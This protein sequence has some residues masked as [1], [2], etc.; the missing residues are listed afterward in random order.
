MALVLH[1]SG[2]QPLGQ[3]DGVDAITSTV[4]GGEVLTFTTVSIASDKASADVA[5]GYLAPG[6]SRIAL[7]TTLTSGSRPLMLCDDGTTYYGTLFGSLVG[8]ACGQVVNGPNTFNGPQLGPHTAAGSGKLTAWD[9]SGLYGVTLD[10]C[11]TNTVTGLQ[12]SNP[13]LSGGAALY[14]TSA[15]LLTPN[16]SSAFE[17]STGA[18]LV[19]GNFIEFRTNGSLVTTPNRLVSALNSPSTVI[20]GV[21]A[22]KQYQAVF[23]F[24]ASASRFV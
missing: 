19:V 17:T 6:T 7:T 8:G 16:K 5:D 15:G 2:E 10:A 13:T 11:D 18:G 20:G 14:A 12:P 21:L 22:T 1:N 24:E 3:Y 23:H 4:K 9:K